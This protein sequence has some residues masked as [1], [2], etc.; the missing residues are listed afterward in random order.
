VRGI[1]KKTYSETIP[2]CNSDLINSVTGVSMATIDVVILGPFERLKVWLMTKKHAEKSL[3]LFINQASNKYDLLKNLF[4]G[5]KVSYVRSMTSWTC[6]LVAEDKIRK[7]VEQTN[8]CKENKKISLIETIF[9][10][11]LGGSINSLVTLP[12]D[13]VKTHLQKSDSFKS[14]KI[15]LTMKELFGNHGLKGLYA[16]WQFRVPAYVIVGIISSGNMQKIDKI[17]NNKETT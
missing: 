9:I 2:I 4:R 1:L 10:G 6:Y 11:T 7:L 5:L 13:A 3:F 17:W 16:G 15:F 12:F 8:G 14:Q